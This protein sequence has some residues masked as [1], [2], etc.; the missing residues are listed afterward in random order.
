[1]TA[2]ASLFGINLGQRIDE[3]IPP[4]F[5][6]VLATGVVF[7]LVVCGWATA[8][9]KPKVAAPKAPLKVA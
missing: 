3:R 5:W 6:V 9:P 2:I 4:M 8:S 1:M 7:G